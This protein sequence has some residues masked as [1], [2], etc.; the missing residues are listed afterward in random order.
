M[1]LRVHELGRRQR[2]YKDSPVS[3]LFFQTSTEKSL[4]SHLS[5]GSREG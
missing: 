4:E 2:R 5:G 3:S 1:K